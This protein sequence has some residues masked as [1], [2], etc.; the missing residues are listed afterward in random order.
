MVKSTRQEKFLELRKQFPFFVFEKYEYSLTERGL[1]IRFCFNLADRYYFYPTLSIPRKSWFAADEKIL[2]CLPVIVFQIGLVEMISYW[3]AA[4]PGRI[5]IKPHPL[6]LEQV[7]WWKKLWYNG[8]GEFFYLNSI[9]VDQETLF[10][11]EAVSGSNLSTGFPSG[12]GAGLI[13]VG[14]GKDSAV[15]LELLGRGSGNRPFILN[16]RGA[17]LESIR[18]AGIP[19]EDLVEAHRTIDP[20]LLKLNNEGFLNGHTPFSAMLA[21]TTVLAALVSGKSFIALSNESSAN[22]ST[23]EGSSVNHQ[24]S[25]SFEFESD[26]R[27]YMTRFVAPQINYYSFLRPLSELQIAGIFARLKQY[28]HVFKSCNAGSK[29]DTWCGSCAKCMFT[30]I[31][32]SPFLKEEEL[33]AIFGK[34]LFAD[35]TLIAVFDQLTGMAAEK[36][37]DCVGTI[38]EVNVALQRTIRQYGNRALPVLLEHYRSVLPGE[39]WLADNFNDYMKM[40]DTN[41]NLSAINKSLLKMWIDG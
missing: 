12:D 9:T 31:I 2:P 22:E 27:G 26:F 8:L 28:H 11:M 15:T 30:W 39:V 14:G 18:V 13:P 19:R 32:L 25:K 29:T 17:T 3:K 5:I 41:N 1:D 34:N 4:C 35:P 7:D 20:A 16:P 10:E 40:F 23:I 33:Q 37:F 6:S 24:Y 38:D 36:P 21:F